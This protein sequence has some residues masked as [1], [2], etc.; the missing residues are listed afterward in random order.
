MTREEGE[1]NARVQIMIDDS[2]NKLSILQKFE[3]EGTCQTSDFNAQILSEKQVD[4][5]GL[6][7]R[8]LCQSASDT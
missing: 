8:R 7:L 5:G 6:F 2:A 3:R 1:A 4:V